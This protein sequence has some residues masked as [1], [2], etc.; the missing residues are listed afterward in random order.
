MSWWKIHSCFARSESFVVDSVGE[1]ELPGHSVKAPHRRRHSLYLAGP[2]TSCGP[3]ETFNRRALLDPGEHS[4]LRADGRP[5]VL[6]RSALGNAFRN[7]FTRKPNLFCRRKQQEQGD[8]RSYDSDESS[9]SS[10]DAV[11]ERLVFQR[12]MPETKDRHVFNHPLKRKIFHMLHIRAKPYMY[13][14]FLF[15]PVQASLADEDEY[16]SQ[17]APPR[18]LPHTTKLQRTDYTA[19]CIRLPAVA[20]EGHTLGR[21]YTPSR[22]LPRTSTKVRHSV[23]GTDHLLR[24]KPVRHQPKD[25]EL[26]GSLRQSRVSTERGF[27]SGASS[28]AFDFFEFPDSRAHSFYTTTPIPANFREAL[29]ENRQH[30]QQL[31]QMAL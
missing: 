13:T 31:F 7:F 1:A 23:C 18:Y 12:N 24:L 30:L 8:S 11:C 16:E 5:C 22:F 19:S 20:R 25:K 4:L 2:K 9:I 28:T 6:Q 17:H 29:D 10:E 26:P 15:R 27:R 14:Y 21:P 3:L